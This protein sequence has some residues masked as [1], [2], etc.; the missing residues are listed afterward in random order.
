MSYLV[1]ATEYITIDG[2]PLSTPAWTTTDLTELLD[3]PENRGSNLVI[4]RRPGAIFRAKIRDSKIV[5][6]PIVIFGDRDAE[7][8]VHADP[9][10]GLIDNI[11]ALKAAL[12]M[13]SFPSARLLTY[14]RASG[15]VEATCQ[16]TPKLDISPIG[17]TT[18]RGVLTIEIPSGV[19]RSTTNTVINQS[20][21]NDTTFNITVP[22]AGEVL[23]VTYNIPGEANS[24]TLTNNTTLGVLSYPA[25]ITT[26]LVVNTVAYTAFDGATNVSG[27]IQTANTPFWL[28]LMPGTNQLRIQRPGSPSVSMSI[29]FRAVWL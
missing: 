3:G 2:V 24:L 12:F 18:A 17:P 22:G 15:N 5:N 9:R 23:G 21:G 6:I 13:P 11:N 19:L 28:P 27:K 8:N 25:P 10:Q 26:G 14:Y 7:N 1:T 29:T 16:T 4:P 20:I